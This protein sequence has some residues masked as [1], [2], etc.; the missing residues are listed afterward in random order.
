MKL[1]SKLWSV[2]DPE[3]NRCA[4]L[5]VEN[6]DCHNCVHDSILNHT[7]IKSDCV[8][9]HNTN[10]KISLCKNFLKTSLSLFRH[11]SASEFLKDIDIATKTAEQCFD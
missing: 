8:I 3:L 9:R 4:K 11:R 5:S 2:S 1:L 7:F 10:H 6:D